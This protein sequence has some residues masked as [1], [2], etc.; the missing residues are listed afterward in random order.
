MSA[1]PR[2]LAACLLLI[3]ATSAV[4]AREY[5]VEFDTVA[6]H[7]TIDGA[8]V[9]AGSLAQRGWRSIGDSDGR[10]FANKTRATIR[11]F[12]VKT[13]KAGD[14]F[15]IDADAGGDLFPTVWVKT[16]YTEAY[17]MD[18]NIPYQ[19]PIPYKFW[20]RVIPANSEQEIADCDASHPV[21]P[22]DGRAFTANPPAP[23]GPDWIKVSSLPVAA[24]ETW[25]A[26]IS[27]TPSEYRTIQAY[28][29]SPDK[30]HVVFVSKG[31]L[32]VFNSPT[33]DVSAVEEQEADVAGVNSI[34]FRDGTA[35]LSQNGK[36][37]MSFQPA[38]ATYAKYGA[39]ATSGDATT[40]DDASKQQSE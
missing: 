11:A 4:S 24:D 23:T 9:G 13:N 14:R 32:L 22:F 7:S 28:A 8:D 30:K 34:V 17:F 15:R 3:G 10:Y 6:G 18:G 21:C 20:M 27:A 31:R 26:L 12:Y 37:V 35:I 38:G 39:A 16:D 33:G 25:L 1:Q 19:S 36:E 29:E 2:Q 40:S 5:R